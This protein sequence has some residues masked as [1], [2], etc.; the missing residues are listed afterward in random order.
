MIRR[1]PRSTLFPYTTLFRSPWKARPSMRALAADCASDTSLP[2]SVTTKRL[3]T[4]KTWP[5]TKRVRG[6][7]TGSHSP[8]PAMRTKWVPIR[9]ATQPALATAPPPPEPRGSIGATREIAG[10]KRLGGTDL[11]VLGGQVEAPCH[12]NGRERRLVFVVVGDGE[13]FGADRAVHVGYRI[14]VSHR[15]GGLA[16]AFH[17]GDFDGAGKKRQ[18]AA[19]AFERE[20]VLTHEFGERLVGVAARLAEGEGYRQHHLA[21]PGGTLGELPVDV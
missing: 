2:R 20:R 9:T 21:R 16:Q 10:L 3:V 6:S 5:T 1:P 8:W 15:R 4:S 17:D 7:M 11:D 12:Q 13:R 19:A 18:V 14:Q